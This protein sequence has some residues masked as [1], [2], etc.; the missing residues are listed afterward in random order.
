[1][2]SAPSSDA[3]VPIG[4]SFAGIACG[5]KVKR[6]DLGLLL[7]E[8][9][10]SAAGCFTVSETRAASVRR[11]E[12]LLPRA[13]VRAVV[14]ASGNAN[15]MCGAHATADD[16]AVAAAIAR[17]IDVKPEDVLTAATGVIGVPFPAAKVEA[18]AEALAQ[19]LV[20]D[21]AGFAEAILTTDTVTKTARREIY[22]AGKRVRLLGIGKGSGM[23]HPNMAT[24]LAFLACDASISPELLAV[25]LRG[26]VAESFQ[27]LSVDAD[28]STND[29]VIAMANGLAGAPAIESLDSDAGKAFARALTD[30]CVELARAVAKDGEGARRLVTVRLDGAATREDARA[31]ARAVVESNLVKAALFGADPAAG[32]IVAAIGARAAERRLVLDASSIDVTMQGFP[33]IRG[34]APALAAADALRARLREDAVEIAIR[35][36]AGQHGATAWGCDLSY[37]YVRINAD[38]ATVLADGPSGA[39][40]RDHRL[41]TKTPELKTEVLVSALRFIERFAGTRAVIRYGQ[42]TLGRRDLALRFAE[43]VRLLSAVGLRPILVQA[44]ASE[45]VV[46]SLARAGVRAVGLSGADGNLFRLDQHS[47]RLSVDPDVVETLLAKGYIPVVVPEITE[48]LEARGASAPGV[49]LVAA[50]IAVACGAKKLIYLSEAPGLTFG[51]MLVSEISAEELASRL[52]SGAIDEPARPLARGAMRALRGGVDSVHFIDERTPHVVVAELFTESGVGTM[53]R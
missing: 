5:I 17:A 23:V 28:T 49:D 37:D 50:E 14:V 46:T 19:A 3:K 38:Y 53:A 27:M 11:S 47:E 31:L 52:E 22:V 42:V 8:V 33:V 9:P 29:A 48:E 21:P 13:G 41:E 34:G 4:Y 6:R 2:E 45:L 43:D 36:G 30:V 15:A 7:S 26:A 44:G 1:M 16:L 51:G 12:A 35:V 40:R 39:V 32:R 25:A 20:P 18:G 24:V 10:A